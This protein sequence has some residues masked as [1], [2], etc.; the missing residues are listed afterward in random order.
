M[1]ISSQKEIVPHACC[2]RK[3][4]LPRQTGELTGN[5]PPPNGRLRGNRRNWRMGF[6]KTRC[7][8]EEPQ[9]PA[10]P[11]VTAT[12][13][14][15]GQATRLRPVFWTQRVWPSAGCHLTLWRDSPDRGP[16]KNQPACG[17]WPLVN[18]ATTSSPLRAVPRNFFAV[19]H[20]TASRDHSG[21]FA[22]RVWQSTAPQLGSQRLAGHRSPSVLTSCGRSPSW[23]R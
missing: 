7:L 2:G 14:R 13:A 9:W 8:T 17:S 20:S 22:D 23:Q 1:A 10:G 5:V 12:V 18:V 6:Q 3:K 15:T 16:Q 11:A 21:T 4:E 19:P